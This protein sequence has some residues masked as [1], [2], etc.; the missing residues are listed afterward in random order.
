MLVVWYRASSTVK[1]RQ[2]E[3]RACLDESYRPVLLLL[4]QSNG[5]SPI[6][7]VQH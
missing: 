7:V 2:T 6:I 5:I 3:A 1:A 4:Y